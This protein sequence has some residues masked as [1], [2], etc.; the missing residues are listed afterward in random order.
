MAVDLLLRLFDSQPELKR[1]RKDRNA[2]LQQCRVR[3]AGAVTDRQNDMARLDRAGRRFD[4]G[5]L[6][7]A[8]HETITPRVETV[9]ASECF[10]PAAEVPADHGQLVAAEMG[11]ILVDETRSAAAL[12]EPVEDVLDIGPRDAAGQFAVAEGAGATFTIQVI[13]LGFER[14][15]SIEI[16]KC[17]NSFF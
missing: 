15:A 11:T 9:F 13:V 7:T 16:A 8:K 14:T 12:D 2:L 3:V 4:A 5:H 10:N 1:F 6:F 17:R